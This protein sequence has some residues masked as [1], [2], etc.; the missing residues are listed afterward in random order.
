MY[1]RVSSI[2][3]TAHIHSLLQHYKIKTLHIKQWNS[4]QIPNIND[5]KL[6]K[7]QLLFAYRISSMPHTI[8]S[9]KSITGIYN[10]AI[11]KIFYSMRDNYIYELSYTRKRCLQCDFTDPNIC[12]LF[13]THTS[14]CPIFLIFAGGGSSSSSSSSETTMIWGCRRGKG[15]CANDTSAHTQGLACFAFAIAVQ[16]Y[17]QVWTQ[18]HTKSEGEHT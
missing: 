17:R 11:G 9:L 18:Y 13:Y 6:H 14:S 10:E 3:E 1:A 2:V 4:K 7:K 16:W 8:A 12:M 15:P 5:D